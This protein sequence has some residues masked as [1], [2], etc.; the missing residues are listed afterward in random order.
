MG[1]AAAPIELEKKILMGQPDLA[2]I[3]VGKGS[4]AY[5]PQQAKQAVQVLNPKMVIPTHYKTAAAN[6]KNCDLVAVDE[7]LQLVEGMPV[8]RHNS[9]KITL[10][11][12]DFPQQESV[13]QLLSYK[14]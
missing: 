6:K 7:F 3:P 10:T 5:N 12:S 14:F 4:K 8:R 9:N 2:L 1:W 11:A 13:I